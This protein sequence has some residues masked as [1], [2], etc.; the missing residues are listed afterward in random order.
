MN[1]LLILLFPILLGAC[2]ILPKGEALDVYLLPAARVSRHVEAP[3]GDWVLRVRQPQSS[4]RIDTTRIAV[5]PQGDL[6]S[7]YKGARW[8]DR[9]PRLLRDRIINA[10]RDDG[11][12]TA[13]ISEDTRI[14]ADLELGGDL[15]A[16]QSEYHDG[17]IETHILLEARLVKSDSQRIIARHRFEVRQVST[18]SSVSDVVTAFGQAADQLSEQLLAWTMDQADIA[19]CHGPKV[20]AP[21]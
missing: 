17:R 8:S 13:V 11:R 7:T 16:F 6:L 5:L 21:S 12:L 18:G 15:G 3:K 9:A 4:E 1:R 2:S 19:I 10:F 14:S 20:T